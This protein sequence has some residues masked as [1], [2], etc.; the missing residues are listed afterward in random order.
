MRVFNCFLDIYIP[1][2][3]SILNSA[4]LRQNDSTPSPSTK[5]VPALPSDSGKNLEVTLQSGHCAHA[6]AGTLHSTAKSFW[7]KCHPKIP[8]CDHFLL[9]TQLP[10][11]SKP[12]S[13]LSCTIKLVSLPVSL[14]PTSH[15]H[16]PV[17]TLLPERYFFKDKSDNFS[18]L[19]KALNNKPCQDPSSLQKSN[20][21]VPALSLL[22]DVRLLESVF[23][24]S[25]SL[26]PHFPTPPQATAVCLQN[27]CLQ[28]DS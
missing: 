23:L 1:F 10:P 8:K 19:L 5:P 26:L 22:P 21:P 24:N 12:P 18:L 17:A 13:S 25:V 7:S 16:S 14:L 6:R 2:L 9:L 20:A 28:G 11:C 3:T 15:H 27:F 4:S